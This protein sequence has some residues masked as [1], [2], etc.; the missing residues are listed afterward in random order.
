MRNQLTFLPSNITS[1]Q[2]PQKFGNEMYI[3]ELIDGFIDHSYTSI[4]SIKYQ[5]SG[6]E[7]Y[8]IGD[9]EIILEQDNYLVVNNNQLVTSLPC[10]TEK[11]ITIFLEPLTVSDVFKN[12]I[13]TDDSLLSNPSDYED[14]Q[15]AFFESS[16]F[17]K[18]DPIGKSLRLLANS[19][20][21][22]KNV[23]NPF[24]EDYF[25]EIS[26]DLILSQ[27]ETFK[28]IKDIG[29]AKISTRVEL[30]D[31]MQ[32]ARQILIENWNKGICL[33]SVSSQ[34]YM[35]PYHFHRT[36][37]KAYKKSP[38]VFHLNVRMKKS[39]DLL[40]TNKYSVSDVAMLAGYSDIFAF[41]K[42]FKKHYGCSPSKFV[43][44]VSK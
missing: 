23:S 3:S 2:I 44:R 40:E 8:K 9:R 16:Y 35:S 38:L 33:N 43:C 15:I 22:I 5:I 36:F 20:D 4:Y 19:F 31:R 1:D 6:T 24:K 14:N 28:Q 32:R 41:S 10:K 18:S 21:I 27:Q 39:K 26:K 30:F 13:N 7:I 29:C 11:A 12:L 42:A 25:Y 37:S 34:V 17:V